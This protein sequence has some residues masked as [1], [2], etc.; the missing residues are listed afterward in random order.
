MY[1]PV[2][3]RGDQDLER[4]DDLTVSL[5]REIELEG[6][7]DEDQKKRLLQIADRCPVHRTLKSEIIISTKL[8]E[9]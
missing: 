2:I 1:H 7:L 5:D 4:F 3:K 6:P 9:E 8:R